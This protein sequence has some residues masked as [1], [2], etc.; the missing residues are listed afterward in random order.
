MYVGHKEKIN[1]LL[2][3]TKVE[4]PYLYLNLL[5]SINNYTKKCAS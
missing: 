1:C 2:D 4:K 5:V 3:H